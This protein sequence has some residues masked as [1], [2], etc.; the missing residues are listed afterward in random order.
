M[1][2]IKAFDLAPKSPYMDVHRSIA[3]KVVIAPDLF[4]KGCAA[5]YTVLV[6][7]QKLEQ[8][9]FFKSKHY[10][11]SRYGNL[12]RILVYYQVAY[13]DEAVAVCIMCFM[14]QP[15]NTYCQFLDIE[16]ACN[17]IVGFKEIVIGLK[18]VIISQDQDR[19][20]PF[21]L[22]FFRQ[23]PDFVCG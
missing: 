14:E 16:R 17:E 10:Q 2:V 21:P 7:C 15:F 13:L 20:W 9:I 5:E 8:F 22:D 6:V 23:F 19:E 12:T 4:E 1:L 3:A 18:Y 11:L